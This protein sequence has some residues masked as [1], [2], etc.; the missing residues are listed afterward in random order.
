MGKV[1]VS[2]K[3]D[4]CLSGQ[5]YVDKP[6]SLRLTIAQPVLGLALFYGRLL[7]PHLL[8]NNKIIFGQ[9]FAF[10]LPF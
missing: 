9:G 8:Q 6:Q 5:L 10:E 7:H 2:A 3:V 1:C 4:L